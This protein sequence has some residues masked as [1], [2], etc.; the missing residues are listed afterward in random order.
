MNPILI[1]GERKI[2]VSASRSFRSQDALTIPSYIK[3]T[4][5]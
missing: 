5:Q 1:C 4:L 2:Y 3:N